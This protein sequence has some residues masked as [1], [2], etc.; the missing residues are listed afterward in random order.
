L[1]EVILLV[2]ADPGVAGQL[3]Q[4]LQPEVVLV[5]KDAESALNYLLGNPPAQDRQLPKVILL[6]LSLPGMGGLELLQRIRSQEDLLG[7]PVVVRESNPELTATAYESGASSVLARLDGE[8]LKAQMD[9][10]SAFWGMCE[11]A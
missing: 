1:I 11:R 5:M 4:A 3:S 8:D 7:L 6:S 9:S 10:L 2:E